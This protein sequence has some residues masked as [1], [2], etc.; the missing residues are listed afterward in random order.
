VLYIIKG[1]EMTLFIILLITI[2][3][4][5]IAFE[6]WLVVRDR[7]HGKGKTGIDQGTRYYNFIAIAVGITGAAVLNGNSKFFFPGGR[8]DTVFWIGLCIMLLGLGL[9][10]WA[11]VTLGASFRTTVETHTYQHVVKSGPYRLVRHP[12][13]SG[14]IMMCCGYGIA[15]Q[16]WLSLAFAVVLPLVVLL[17]RIRIEEAALISSMGSDYEEYQSKTKKLVPWVW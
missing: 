8:S 11:V 2:S 6:I 4:I 15:V 14:L 13:Y 10:I 7:I 3:T 1:D 16:N 17:Y 12:S 5:W 9:R